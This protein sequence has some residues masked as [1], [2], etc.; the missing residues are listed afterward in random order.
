MQNNIQ[1]NTSRNFSLPYAHSIGTQPSGHQPGN[2]PLAS[3]IKAVTNSTENLDSLRTLD[4]PQTMTAAL[5]GQRPLLPKDLVN[6]RFVLQSVNGTPFVAKEYAKLPEL[7]FD[8]KLQ[9]TGNMCNQF[10]GKATL[11]G[12]QLKAEHLA[13]NMMICHETQ[14]N[15]LDGQFAKILN[16]GVQVSL[17]DQQLVLKSG[18][19]TLTYLLVEPQ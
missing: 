18:H 12:N 5:S 6:R 2:L 17:N 8:D 15:E 3:Q 14:L 13:M 1:S 10:F 19:Y 11:S 16:T 9:I 4:D 7:N